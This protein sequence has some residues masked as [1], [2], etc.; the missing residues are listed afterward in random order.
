MILYLDDLSLSQVV[1]KTFRIALRSEAGI[2]IEPRA[3][4]SWWTREEKGSYF[5]NALQ[6]LGMFTVI[7]F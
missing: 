6:L 1:R 7:Y 4:Y 2:A 3:R 5:N